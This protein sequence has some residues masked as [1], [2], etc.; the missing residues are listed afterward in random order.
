MTAQNYPRCL[1]NTLVEEGG[2]S[3]HPSDPG[4]PTM[5]GVIQ[6][7]YDEYRR[8]W[9]APLQSVRHISEAELQIIYRDGY[10]D[11][12]RGDLFPKGP[13]QIVFDIGVNSGPARGIA[14]LRA[15]MGNPTGGAATLARLA[16]ASADQVGIVKRA[17]ARRASFYRGIGT[18][19]VFGRGWLA[20]NARMEAIGVRMCL[21]EAGVIDIAGAIRKEAAGAQIKAK[22]GKQGAAASGG[23]SGAGGGALTQADVAAWDWT[24]WLALGL[25]AIAAVALTLALVWAWK[26]HGARATAYAQALGDRLETDLAT[27]LAK[28]RGGTA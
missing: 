26:K 20:R 8:K 25:T 12:V 10:W 22:R 1:A 17:C 11:K 23:A 24:A 9:N 15:A 28:I 14:I 21:E 19:A 16:H 5:R 13:D 27:L 18:F 3:N 2:W 7:R 4:G 6:A